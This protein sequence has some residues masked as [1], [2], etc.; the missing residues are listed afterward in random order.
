M[1][2][3]LH[4]ELR[5][6]RFMPE[7]PY[8]RTSVKLMRR[9][10]MRSA[11][12]GPG[13]RVEEV[14]VSP[15]VSLKFFRPAEASSPLPVMLWMHGG[16]HLGGSPEQDDSD[17]IAFARD[18]GIVVAAARYRVGLDAPAPASVDDCY[19]ALE[20][21]VSRAE[22]FGVDPTRLAIGGA[23]AG[24]GVAAALVLLAHD[25]GEI[26]IRFQL[27]VYPMLDDRTVTREDLN[28]RRFRVWTTK[29]NRLGWATYLDAAPGS[30]GIAAYASPARREDLTGL[31]PAWIGVGDNDLFLDEDVRYAERLKDA[32]VPCD[33]S[34]VPGAFH[35]F[36][37]LFAKTDVAQDFWRQQADALRAA[38]IATT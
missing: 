14:A 27:L 4:P 7:I 21:L 17:N 15:T 30:D 6:V 11:D 3:P 13:V 33:L 18:L 29:S 37:A 19:D 12:P 16:G 24:G 2:S 10:T 38:G 20:A 23:S 26:P 28:A 22:E 9:F 31:P 34:I 5:R 35:G 1:P 8:T 32:G 36:D 25:R